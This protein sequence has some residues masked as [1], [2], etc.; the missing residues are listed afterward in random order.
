MKNVLPV[1]ACCAL[2]PLAVGCAPAPTKAVYTP[3]TQTSYGREP[4][5][6]DKALTEQLRQGSVQMAAASDSVESALAEA[7]KA[8]KQL[9][10]DAKTAAQDVVDLL[11]DAGATITEASAD[12]P[13]E[14]DVKKNF[15]AADD[16]RKKR[17]AA[18]NDAYRSI[19]T[20]LGTLE[21]LQ[22]QVTGLTSLK[23]TITLAIDDLGDAIEAYG[24]KVES[25][26]EDSAI[27]GKT[28]GTGG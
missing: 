18:G 28:H 6:P 2:L 10:G 1:L 13:T 3:P 7:K 5:D 9:S 16:D 11:D 17:I 19:E 8:V 25:E 15:S 14:A 12:P 20:A 23:D 21:G 24:G 26:Q 27:D 22:Q 4:D